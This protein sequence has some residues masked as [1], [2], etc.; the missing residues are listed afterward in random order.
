M[1]IEKKLSEWVTANLI[2]AEEK[3]NIVLYERNNSFSPWK[4]SYAFTGIGVLAIVLGVISLIGVN[5]WML[6]DVVKLLSGLAFLVLTAFVYA[7]VADGGKRELTAELVLMLFCGLL[8]AYIGLTGQVFHL[9]APLGR[10]FLLWTIISFPLLM[11][12]KKPLLSFIVVGVFIVSLLS[13]MINIPLLGE[14]ITAL[15]RDVDQAA[16][17]MFSIGFIFMLW[18]TVPKFANPDINRAVNFYALAA[19]VAISYGLDMDRGIRGTSFI[20]SAKQS[21]SG[22]AYFNFSYAAILMITGIRAFMPKTGKVAKLAAVSYIIMSCLI[23][24]AIASG[25]GYSLPAKILFTVWNFIVLS[26]TAVYAAVYKRNY[27]FNIAFLLMG[28]RIIIFFL[29][30]QKLLAGGIGLITAGCLLLFAVHMFNKY[31]NTLLNMIKSRF[32]EKTRL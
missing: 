13:E 15:M 21:L 24:T 6:P 16:G 26:E 25:I 4:L 12:S 20:L 28:M 31:K 30:L 17:Y 32:E 3:D 11:I 27:L 5:W 10:G 14:I 19:I 23:M 18:M 9:S 2:T 22:N 7:K 29:A 1:R 8:L